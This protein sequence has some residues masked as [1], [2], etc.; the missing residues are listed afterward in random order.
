VGHVEV[1]DLLFAFIFDLK[2]AIPVEV[3]IEAERFPVWIARTAR[4]EMGFERRRAG[5]RVR[6]E[7][8]DRSVGIV[9][10]AVD[11]AF[12]RVAEELHVVEIAFGPDLQVNSRIEAAVGHE[13][14]RVE[15]IG[16]TVVVGVHHSD[17]AADRVGEEER[18]VI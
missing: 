18:A 15:R 7:P 16:V 12:L 10:D 11:R 4:I 2:A 3:P 9:G 14:R 1:R 6:G 13:G 8:G 17:A 5:A